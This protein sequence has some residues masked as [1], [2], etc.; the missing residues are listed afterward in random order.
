M[1]S[2][3]V[4]QRQLDRAARLGMR[5]N[6][7]MNAK[8]FLVRVDGNRVTP[9]N[10]KMVMHKAAYDVLGLLESMDW[11]EEVIGC[12]NQLGWNVPLL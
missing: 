10:P 2:R 8:F 11:L 7:G 1:C 12:M 9:A 6:L 5:F 3:T 4:L